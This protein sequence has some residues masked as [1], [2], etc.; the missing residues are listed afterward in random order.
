MLN[1]VILIGNLAR[2]PELRYTQSG[3]AVATF[4]LA[5]N[6]PKTK[7]GAEQQ[8]DWINIVAWRQTAD[9][10]ANYLAKGRQCAV[11]GRIQTRSYDN[12]EGKRVFVTEV[13]AERIQ[14][15]GSKDGKNTEQ[16]SDPFSTSGQPINISDDDLPF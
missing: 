12:Q 11:E 4:T 5:V 3:I 1:K 8:P 16:Q 2:D 14:L 10:A 13:V 7:D 9:I 15:L 6:R